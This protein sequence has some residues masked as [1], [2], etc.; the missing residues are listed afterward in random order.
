MHVRHHVREI[1][2]CLDR[3][4]RGHGVVR[5]ARLNREGTVPCRATTG[6]TPRRTRPLGQHDAPA[7]L[8]EDRLADRRVVHLRFDIS[9]CRQH[10]RDAI[11]VH[12]TEPIRY[13]AA[14]AG[15]ARPGPRGISPE[16]DVGGGRFS[17]ILQYARD[18]MVHHTSVVGSELVRRDPGILLEVCRNRYIGIR[19]DAVGRHGER[20]EE[21]ENQVRFANRPAFGELRH[22]GEVLVVA[23]KR[24]TIDPGGDGIDF[25]LCE[26]RVVFVGANAGVS[27]PRR[28]LS[29]EHLG[30][31]CS[32]PGTC[33]VISE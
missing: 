29:C 21:R 1:G 18:D 2:V 32:G 28:H 25:G 33:V 22:G 13:I 23:L 16:G 26:A 17:V 12:A 6:A 31:Y 3:L 10:D 4:P 7:A 11:V 30:L 9:A 5:V 8:V 14:D 15:P 19:H 24:P 27:A 20:L